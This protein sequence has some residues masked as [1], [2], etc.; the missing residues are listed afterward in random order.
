[1][2]R[3][4]KVLGLAL[5]AIAIFDSAA[6]ADAI[7]VPEPGSMSVF[8]IGTIGLVLAARLLKSKAS[9]SKAV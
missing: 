8:A 4:T 5:I 9:I 7:V 1:M 6:L 2:I 3:F